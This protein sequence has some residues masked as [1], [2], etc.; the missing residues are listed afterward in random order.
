MADEIEKKYRLTGE[1][2][3]AVLSRLTEFG[4][5]YEGEDAEENILFLGGDLARKQAVL[6]L[7][8]IGERTIL[9]YK[10]RVESETAYKHHLEYETE[11]ADFAAMAEIF[12]RLGYRR[13]LI[14]E[15][16]RRTWKLRGV[17]VVLDE[18]PFG[19]YMEIEGS[20]T[21]IAEA[22]MLLDAEDFEVEPET[23]PL[24]TAKHGRRRG[25]FIEA[26]F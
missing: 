22:E 14:Y 25:D 18:L 26:R 4:A 19:D 2:K 21:G 23:Y 24:L 16:R 5:V 6:R 20:M 9:A 17:E 10:Q 11:I 15:K 13:S 1:Q 8:R 7:R 3:E 12:E